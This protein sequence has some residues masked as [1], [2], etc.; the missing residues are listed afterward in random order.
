MI[1]KKQMRLRHPKKAKH[2]ETV[3]FSISVGVIS[4]VTNTM[5]NK[6]WLPTPMIESTFVSNI[7]NK[8]IAPTPNS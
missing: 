3:S 4:E 6:N 7:C 8:V 1:H 2:P 5:K